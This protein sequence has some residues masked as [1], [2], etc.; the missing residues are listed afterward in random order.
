MMMMGT[1]TRNTV[2]T[3]R[4]P[5]RPPIKNGNKT[6]SHPAAKMTL[7]KNRTFPTPAASEFMDLPTVGAYGG[8]RGGTV[9][10]DGRLVG[11]VGG[12]AGSGGFGS[13]DMGLGPFIQF[14][15]RRDL[16]KLRDK[17]EADGLPSANDIAL[18]W[19]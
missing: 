11:F 2:P 9:G 3:G 10:T 6:I 17:T 5:T 7:S 8:E 1:A 19:R 14:G 18:R 15:H 16:Y 13:V 4:A 12:L